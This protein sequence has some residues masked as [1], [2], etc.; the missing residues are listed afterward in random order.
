MHVSILSKFNL[1]FFSIL[2]DTPPKNFVYRIKIVGQPD[3]EHA[4]RKNGEAM[5]A[6]DVHEF[7]QAHVQKSLS[8][9][10]DLNYA[11]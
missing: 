1:L 8:D 7:I 10:T 9:Y 4:I 11:Y 3:I 5:T 6:A 2:F